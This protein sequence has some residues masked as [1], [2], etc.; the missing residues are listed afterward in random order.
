MEKIENLVQYYS[1]G[2]EIEDDFETRK[3]QY[4]QIKHRFEI[5]ENE[6]KSYHFYSFIVIKNPSRLNYHLFDFEKL[7]D[8]SRKLSNGMMTIGTIPNRV[9]FKKYFLG[10]VRTISISQEVSDE[11]P[12]FNLNYLVFSKFDNLDV[13]IKNQ[14]Q[15]RLRMIDPSLEMTFNYLGKLENVEIERDLNISTNVNYTSE[16]TQKL[17]EENL[18]GIFNNQ[19]QR[20]RF[21]GTLYKTNNLLK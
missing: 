15:V 8:I 16:T 3:N 5:S 4:E 11:Y 7:Q 6:L 1:I 17:G 18:Q 14:L 21:F 19:F 10:G 9:F 12:S 13:R 20:P 2:N